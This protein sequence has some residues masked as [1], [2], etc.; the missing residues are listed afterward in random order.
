MGASSF[1]STS[2]TDSVAFQSP[3]YFSIMATISSGSKSP[4]TQIAQLLGT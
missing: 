2:G 1:I 3:K 4:A